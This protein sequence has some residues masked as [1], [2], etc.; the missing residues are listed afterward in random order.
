MGTVRDAIAGI[1][2]HYSLADFAATH[3]KG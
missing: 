2:D 3:P 1:L